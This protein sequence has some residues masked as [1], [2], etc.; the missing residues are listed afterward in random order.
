MAFVF[1]DEMCG[2]VGRVEEEKRKVAVPLVGVDVKAEV[3]G[4][5]GQVEIAQCYRNTEDVEV[6]AVYHFPLDSANS[7]CAFQAEYE[8]GTVVKGEVKEKG[9]A[10]K[11]YSAAIQEG[12]QAQLLEQQRPDIFTLSVGRIPPS[13]FVTVRITYITTLKAEGSA[14]LGGG[15]RRQ[16]CGARDTLPGSSVRGHTLPSLRPSLPS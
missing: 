13:S 6:E 3:H 12:K 10:R 15:R 5:I 14:M 2:L 9:Q 1:D 8:D 4:F 7:V 11:E 16:R